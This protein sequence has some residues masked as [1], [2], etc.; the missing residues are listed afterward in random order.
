MFL[1]LSVGLVR[2]VLVL[3]KYEVLSGIPEQ[4]RLRTVSRNGL[5]VS[6]VVFTDRNHCCFE[7][8][9]RDGRTINV[10]GGRPKPHRSGALRAADLGR[11]LARRPFFLQLVIGSLHS[12]RYNGRIEVLLRPASGE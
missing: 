6:E 10:H 3:R 1:D 9:T 11:S 8:R 7:W 5:T 12:P 2:V 4:N